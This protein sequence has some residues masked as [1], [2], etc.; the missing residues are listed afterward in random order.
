ME[1][2]RLKIQDALRLMENAKA[3]GW[4]IPFEEE[5]IALITKLKNNSE[6]QDIFLGTEHNINGQF[7]TQKQTP[8]GNIEFVLTGFND[9]I[10]GPACTNDCLLRLVKSVR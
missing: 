3:L 7:L 6:L 10:L 4:R 8:S 1:P 2:A 9:G 5:L